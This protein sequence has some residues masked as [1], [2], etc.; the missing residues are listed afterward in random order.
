[1][2]T[3][4]IFVFTT[5]LTGTILLMGAVCVNAQLLFEENFNYADED[6]LTE[7]GWTA[8]SG[9]ETNPITVT[10]PGLTYTDYPSVS[11]NAALLDNTGED[12]SQN[13]TE[14]SSGT[15]YVS[16]LVNVSSLPSGGEYFLHL[17][18]TSMGTKYYAK[19]W[20]FKET[21]SDIEFAVTKKSNSPSYTSND[22]SNNTTYLL[23]IKY[24]FIA[25]EKND[26]VSLFVLSDP[27]LPDT[28]PGTPTQ[29]PI[30]ESE[31][32][33]PANLGTIALRQFD[34]NQNIKIDGIRVGLSW[35]DAPIPVELSSFNAI[36]VGSDIILQWITQ[37]ETENLGFHLYRSL[38]EK[39]HYTKITSEII[40]GMGNSNE[41][42]VYSF[43]DHNV[44][45]GNTYY[46]QLAGV[47]F[48]GN[49]N[50]HGPISVT[51]AAQP[52]QYSLAQNYPNPFNQTTVINFSLKEPGKVVLKIYNLRGKLVRT[53]VETEKLAGLHSVLWDGTNEPGIKV[54][55]GTYLYTLKI[56][57][58]E[59][60]K[61]LVLMK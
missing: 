58:F 1:M 35:S 43:T 21:D 5:L 51:V 3:K 37:S 10:S 12:V 24:E 44:K 29:G 56:N 49:I 50:Y 31:E 60:I 41:S 34:S 11:G 42:H 14:Q 47:D 13:F 9:S 27:D 23:V 6:E 61:K 28:E 54:T 17:G 16:F 33:D 55:S 38:V 57:G 18:P 53:L 22:Y 7:H 40:P 45:V 46:Y 15:I 26:K 48:S 59:Q 8:H 20:V 32:T 19:V 52:H 30:A 36:H 2:R 39:E 4:L 25:G